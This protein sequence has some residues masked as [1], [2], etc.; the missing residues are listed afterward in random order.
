MFGL[1]P[2]AWLFWHLYQVEVIGDGPFNQGLAVIAL[3]TSIIGI[4]VF[5]VVQVYMQTTEFALTDRRIILKKG[6]ISRRT[7]EIPLDALENVN[8]YQTVFQRLFGYGR[9]ELNGSGGSPLHSPPIQDPV[10]VRTSISEA[11]ISI[12]RAPAFRTAHPEKDQSS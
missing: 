11:R 9:L 5:V 4:I 7:N 12:E 2:V 6:F 1:A 8:V 3:I 10:D